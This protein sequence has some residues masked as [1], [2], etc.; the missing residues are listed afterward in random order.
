M[1]LSRT[2]VEVADA[3]EAVRNNVEVHAE[4][5]TEAIE[6][7]AESFAQIRAVLTVCGVFL[8]AVVL[9]RFFMDD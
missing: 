4:R 9:A 1:R 8:T 2:L 3:A 7:M 5:V 6:D